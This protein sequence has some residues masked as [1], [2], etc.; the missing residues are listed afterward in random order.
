MSDEDQIR[1]RQALWAQY[2]ADNNADAWSELFTED[3]R[4]IRPNGLETVG[5][6]AIRDSMISRRGGRPATRH[7]AHV[8]GPAVIRVHGDT[9]ES[10]TDFVA[11]GRDSIETSWE[12]I[13]VGRLN[14]RLVKRDGEWYFSEMSN[15]GYF[16]GSPP[17]DRLPTLS[18]L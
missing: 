14:N 3:A 9:A 11:Y 16:L 13:A 4:Y 5:R 12:I 17:P 6:Q 1:E 8:L 15:R 7:T 2:E 10:A 18:R